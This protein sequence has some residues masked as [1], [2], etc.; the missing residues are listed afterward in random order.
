LKKLRI[1]ETNINI[2]KVIY[3]QPIAKIIPNVKKLELFPL[4]SEIGLPLSSLIF[5]IVLEFLSRII[6]QEKEIKGIK[7]GKENIKLSLFGDDILYLKDPKD[8]I[9]TLRCD[10]HFYQSS[11]I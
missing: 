9:K 7:I 6:R 5:N 1:E 2:I 11:R 10:K 3:C 4:K 8:F